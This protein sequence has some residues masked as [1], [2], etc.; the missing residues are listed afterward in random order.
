MIASIHIQMPTKINP[1]KLHYGK[2][3][4][5]S[6]V[7]KS[8]TPYTYIMGIRFRMH[9]FKEGRKHCFMIPKKNFLV[10]LAIC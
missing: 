7:R 4:I 1:S 8:S 5:I 3:I 9:N 10:N 2:F 6:Q